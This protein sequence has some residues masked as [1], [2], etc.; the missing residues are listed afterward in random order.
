MPIDSP[1]AT[2]T[3]STR[4]TFLARVAVG[5]ALAG[6]GVASGS[7]GLLSGPAGAQ[8]SPGAEVLLGDAGELPAETFAGLAIPLELAAVLAYQ[9]AV[10]A[11]I[12]DAAWQERAQQFQTHHQ[13]VVDTLTPLLD[14]EAD[15]PTPDAQLLSQ[16]TAGGDQAARLTALASVEDTLVAT[17]LY[18]LSGLLSKSLAKT[19]GQ[20]LATEAQ[21]GALLG[22]AGGGSAQE[23][24]PTAVSTDGARTGAG[25]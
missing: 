24:T 17:H 21:Q 8:G 6:V 11:G 16:G 2:A 9:Q 20:V 1:E 7:L 19:V 13:A 10:E 14:E 22:V 12:L 18:A 3:P 4:R 25:S 23:L 15:D 5:G